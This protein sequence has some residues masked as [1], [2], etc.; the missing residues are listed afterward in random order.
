MADRPSP[1][2][3]RGFL[4]DAATRTGRLLD[5]AGLQALKFD[6]GEA[7]QPVVL[8]GDGTAPGMGQQRGRR[9]GWTVNQA[10][11][12]FAQMEATQDLQIDFIEVSF[13]VFAVA[14]DVAIQYK[15]PNDLR[16]GV[17]GGLPQGVLID[18]AQSNAEGAPLL[19]FV[20]GT[21]GIRIYR[22]QLLTNVS[23]AQYA[24]PFFLAAG[25][26]IIV[27][28]LGAGNTYNINVQGRIF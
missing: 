23:V 4:G 22:K 27:T 19:Y 10:V 2:L 1:T 16:D 15:G 3:D 18:R 25:A 6:A 24:S 14:G 11:T 13:S 9:F 21:A 7:I 17:L 8:L 26:R 20:G 5:V 28:P 12:T